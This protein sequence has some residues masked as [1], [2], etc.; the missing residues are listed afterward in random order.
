MNEYVSNH[1]EKI[2][3]IITWE[4]DNY[5]YTVLIEDYNEYVPLFKKEID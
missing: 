4:A 5:L 3:S 1:Q 2:G